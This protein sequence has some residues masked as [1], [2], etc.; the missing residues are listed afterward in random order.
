ME[1]TRKFDI[2]IDYKVTQKER[3]NAKQN[4]TNAEMTEDYIVAGVQS[5]YPMGIDGQ[6]R[7]IYS[8]IQA[9]LA[10]AI[11]SKDYIVELNDV[12]IDFIKAS[13]ALAKFPTIFSKFVVILEDKINAL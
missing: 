8:R 6:K 5:A 3:E 4:P 7:R 11:S 12:E 10:D 13:F 9:K 2:D 1:L